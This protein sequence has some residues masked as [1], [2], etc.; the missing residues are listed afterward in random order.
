MEDTLN[1]MAGLGGRDGC[2]MGMIHTN[3]KHKRRALFVRPI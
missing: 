2:T 3:P 1:Y